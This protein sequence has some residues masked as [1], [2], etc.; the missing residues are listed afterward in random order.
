MNLDKPRVTVLMPAYNAAK[1]IGEAIASVLNQTFADFELLIV[2]DG[3]TDN[4]IDIIR[5]F[6]DSRIRVIGLEGK[7]VSMALNAGLHAAKGSYIAR[8]DADDICLPKRLQRQVHFLD[9]NPSYILIGT[10]AE[11]IVETGEHLFDFRC[12]SYSYDDILQRL[13]Q[14]CPFIHSSVMYRKEEVLKVGGYSPYAHNFEHYLLWVNLVKAGKCCNLP[15]PLIKVRFNSGSVTIDEKWRGDN[16]RKLKQQ[17]IMRGYITELE[18]MKLESIIKK[19][20][21]RKIKESSYHALCCKKF[22]IDNYQP[23]KARWHASKAIRINPNRLDNYGLLITSYLPSKWI[24][25]LR[26]RIPVNL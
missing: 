12:V 8:F 3:S 5:G 14:H 24:K 7:G 9:A 16:F 4:T 19:Q 11:Y 17:I 18:G 23:T 26:H 1:Y 22:L 13:Y 2:N 10:D 15:D 20:E 21:I 25:W 6:E